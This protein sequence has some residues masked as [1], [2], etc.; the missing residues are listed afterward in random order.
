MSIV[1]TC[2]KFFD[3]LILGQLASRRPIEHVDAALEPAWNEFA[4]DNDSDL[5]RQRMKSRVRE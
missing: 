2:A 4:V 3:C 1:P 5:L